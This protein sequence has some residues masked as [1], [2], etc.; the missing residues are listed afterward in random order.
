MPTGELRTGMRLGKPVRMADG[1]VLLQA[2]TVLKEAYIEPLVRHGVAAVYV[3]NPLAPDVIPPDVVPDE[4]RYNLTAELSQ[5]VTQLRESVADA[6]HRYR[7]QINIQPLKQAMT[8]LVDQLLTDRHVVVNLQDIR[9]ADE[10]TL[11]HSVNVCI[12]SILLG[13]ALD[14]TVAELRDLGLGTLMHDI[15]KVA[16]PQEILRK[17]GALTP[18]EF[19]IMSTHT[20]LGAKIL[21][22]QGFVSY[23]A[24]SVALQHHERWGGGGYPA[25]L[26]GEQIFKFARVCAV[27]D[28]YDAMTADRIYRKGMTPARARKV[29]VDEMAHFFDPQMLGAFLPLT[30]PYPVG[31]MVELTGGVVAVVLAVEREHVERPRVRVVLGPGGEVLAEPF[32]VDLATAQH[33]AIRRSITEGTHHLPAA[34]LEADG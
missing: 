27:A 17:A 14:F 21:R 7:V 29:M 15:G 11:G 28:C 9:T 2:G 5:V 33:Y 4:M 32:E 30:A 10:Y 12:L 1:R 13:T 3:V 16:V 22:D 31:S 23:T 6:A 34:L 26:A 20:S 24:A 18:E 8:R 25:G 19:R